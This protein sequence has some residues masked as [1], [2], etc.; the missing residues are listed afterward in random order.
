V[1]NLTRSRSLSAERRIGSPGHGR[2]EPGTV[3]SSGRHRFADAARQWPCHR[4]LWRSSCG[5]VG[6]S[7]VCASHRRAP[8]TTRKSDR[9]PCRS[10]WRD[11]ESRKMRLSSRQVQA[12]CQGLIRLPSASLTQSGR[13]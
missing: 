3:C 2:F 6:R 4:R 11:R 1:G 5:E 8:W 13:S 7:G 10:P 9:R 12:G